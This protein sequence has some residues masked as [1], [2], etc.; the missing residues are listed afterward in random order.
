MTECVQQSENSMVEKGDAKEIENVVAHIQRL[1][2]SFAFDP[3][4]EHSY[5]SAALILCD[6]V[7]SANRRYNEFVKRRLERLKQQGIEQK[8]LSE[9]LDWID[10]LGDSGFTRVWNYNDLGRVKRLRN[11]TRRFLEFKNLYELTGD[12]E[13]LSRWGKIS[14]L[15]DFDSFGVAGIGLATFQYL[16]ILCGAETVK[17]DVHLRQAVEDSLNR[18]IWNNKKVVAL[19]EAASQTMDIP[20]KR[21]DYAIWDHYSKISR[22]SKKCA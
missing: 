17:P 7:L 9:L 8:S 11:L 18:K 21:L 14:T 20:A 15:D 22:S 13:T 2:L 12:F 1:N 19:I 16:R 6:A 4:P 3:P 5:T 10:K